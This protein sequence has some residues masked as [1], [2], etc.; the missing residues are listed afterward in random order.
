MNHLK[1]LHPSAETRRNDNRQAIV[2]HD[3]RRQRDL[4]FTDPHQHHVRGE[5][6]PRKPKRRAF[7]DPRVRSL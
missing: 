2:G 6:V 3:I 4:D 1:A 5:R 7:E